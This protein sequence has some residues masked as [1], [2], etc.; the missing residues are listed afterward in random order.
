MGDDK[1]AVLLQLMSFLLRPEQQAL[2]Y[3]KGYFYPGP[4]VKNV[5]LAMAPKES[6]DIV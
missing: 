6:Q 1:V 4:A 3:D 5:T 2:T